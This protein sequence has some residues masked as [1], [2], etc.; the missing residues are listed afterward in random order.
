VP[1]IAGLVDVL[2]GHGFSR[3]ADS[4]EKSRALAPEGKLKDEQYSVIRNLRL[5]WERKNRLGIVLCFV[6]LAFLFLSRSLSG[7]DL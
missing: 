4:A 1:Q 7:I 6:G 5:G 2:K 3:A